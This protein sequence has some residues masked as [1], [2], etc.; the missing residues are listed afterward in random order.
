MD[1]RH[2]RYFVCVA[3]EKKIGRAAVRLHISQPPLT[4][5]IQQLEEQLGVLLFRRTHRGVEL[6]D[7]GRVFYDD[8]RNILG[9]TERAI[10]RS[11]KAAQGL[12]GRVDLAI[13]GSGIFGAIPRLIRAF[14]EAH[15]EV[16]IFLH[17]MVKDEQIDALRQRRITLAF[18]R[19][20]RPIDGLVSE[21]LLTEPLYVA[22]PSGSP[23]TARTA[24]ALQELE[25]VPL[26]LYPTGS[27]PS[28]I[29]RVHEMCRSCGFT[30]QVAQEVGDVVH[31]VAL[32]ATGF[33]VTV[34]PQSATSMAMPGI[35]YRPLHHPADSR[36]D[37]CCI[38]RDD[39]DSPILQSLLASMRREAAALQ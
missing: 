34:V 15:P 8:A 39:D 26:V 27:R 3:E 10:E 32:V 12:L 4:R 9:L 37:L 18:N 28:F 19:L 31:A 11:S 22:L 38:Y 29:D 30:P 14:R 35:A 25:Q 2:L 23:L 1:L 24:V 33:S 20:M 7:A 13:F 36:V 6:T 5:Q 21:T 16:S 17:N